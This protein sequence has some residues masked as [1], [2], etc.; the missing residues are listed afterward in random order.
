MAVD[1][2]VTTPQG[3]EHVNSNTNVGLDDPGQQH[4]EETS[5][6]NLLSCCQHLQVANQAAAAMP[7][8]AMG[9]GRFHDTRAKLSGDH[10]GGA[11]WATNNNML[12]PIKLTRDSIPES[13]L[14]RSHLINTNH[15]T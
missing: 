11:G 15:S 10:V 8:T 6:G 13:Y 14:I 4:L 7:I 2:I 5:E 12:P 3:R 1:D 9:R